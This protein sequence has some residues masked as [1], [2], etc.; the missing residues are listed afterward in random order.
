MLFQGGVSMVASENKAPSQIVFQQYEPEFIDIIGKDPE[1]HLI[2]EGFTYTEGP[3]F[4]L[5]N[6][7][8]CEGYLFFTET[9]K[10]TIHLL[11]WNGIIPF[12]QITPLSYSET[13]IFRKPAN[14][15]N[16]LTADLEGNLLA[17]EFA[18]RR[19]SITKKDGEIKPLVGSCLGKPFN[20][21]NDLVVKSDGTVWF[22]DCSY[23]CQRF[24]VECQLPNAVYCFDPKTNA[25]KIVISDLVQPNGIAFSPNEKVLYVTDTGAVSTPPGGFLYSGNIFDVKK[26]HAVYAFDV[27]LEGILSNKRL[28]VDVSPGVPDGIK[29]DAKGNLYVSAYDGVQIFNPL[30]KLIGKIALPKRVQNITFGGKDNNILFICALGSIYAVKVNLVG[31][32][33]IS[34]LKAAL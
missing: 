25:L 11:R 30:G 7:K 9:P 17:A 22:T 28:F 19:I 4:F 34:T 1:L 16:G 6:A 14:T 29:V 24:S 18:G 32:K 3:V 23:G 2:A 8:G 13:A 12:N 27:S 26:P 21:P 31:A 20:S 33:P 15:A 5:S 10:D